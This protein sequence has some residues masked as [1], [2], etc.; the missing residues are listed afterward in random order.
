M[1]I[2][3]RK[4]FLIDGIGAF[5]SAFMLG[6]VLVQFESFFG[7]PRKALYFLAA[8]PCLYLLYDFY[9]YWQVEKNLKWYL[10][11][12]AMANLL[13][14]FISIAFLFQHQQQLTIWGW[15][16]FILE[17]LIIILLVVIQAKIASG[18]S[19]E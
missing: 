6:I 19:T 8:L 13:Y 15:T 4:L 14:Y 3:P 11:G 17:M 10:K 16:Y 5:I 18:M 7:M 1:K 12:I 9:V 2:D